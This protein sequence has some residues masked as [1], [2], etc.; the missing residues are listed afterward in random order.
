MIN[1]PPLMEMIR[2]P[3]PAVSP[4]PLA[5]LP[6][7]TNPEFPDLPFLAGF[8]HATSG[9]GSISVLFMI[10]VWLRQREARL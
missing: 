5:V 6:L 8:S 1:R 7:V 4:R 10:S 3:K 2:V 9:C